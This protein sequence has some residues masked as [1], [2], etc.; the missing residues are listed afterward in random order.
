[1]IPEEYKP[2]IKKLRETTECL[3]QSW[4]PTSDENKFNMNV[5]KNTATVRYY[6]YEDAYSGNYGY[7]IRFDI[8][9]EYGE[10][11]DGFYVV[12]D[13]PDYKEMYEFYEMARRN[14]LKVDQTI[15]QMLKDL[16]TF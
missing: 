8:L 7:G 3:R 9:N 10:L 5:G 13:E 2:L 1:M 4:N 6:T 14:A 12:S 15:S 16:D 11:V